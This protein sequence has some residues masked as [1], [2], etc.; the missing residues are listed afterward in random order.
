M[1][2]LTRVQ[3]GMRGYN[4]FYLL[5]YSHTKSKDLVETMGHTLIEAAKGIDGESFRPAG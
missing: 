1:E 3:G 2:P 5:S 4:V